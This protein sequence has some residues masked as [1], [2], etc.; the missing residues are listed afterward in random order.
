METEN[1]TFIADESQQKVIEA[2]NG[3]HLVLAPPGCGKTQIL[4]E[5]IRRAHAD[6]V[7]YA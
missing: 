5:R 3:Y 2:N 1:K 7:G 6:G 4:T